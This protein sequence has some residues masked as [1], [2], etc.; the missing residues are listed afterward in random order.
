MDKTAVLKNLGKA[1]KK[2]AKNAGISL[3]PEYIE[4]LD[5][6]ATQA[7]EGTSR[8]EVVRAMIDAWRNPQQPAMAEQ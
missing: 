8:S 6:L 4:V 3:A 5:E 1:K 2:L 7:G